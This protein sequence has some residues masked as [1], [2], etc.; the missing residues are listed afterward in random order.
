MTVD[1]GYVAANDAERAR[2]RALVN[3]LSDADL[4]RPMPGGW[5]VASVLGHLAFWDQRIAVLLE[6]WEKS[7]TMPPG[8][9]EAHVDWIND[10]GKPFLLGMDPRRMAAL[11]VTIAETV[12]RRVG[13]LPDDRVARAAAPGSSIKL[14]RAEHRREH[15][16]EI[17]HTLKR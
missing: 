13:A 3:R 16:D 12:D 8:F 15:L 5:T 4:A 7:G 6:T 1:R 17:E 2:L 10:A 14:L 9:D 11:A